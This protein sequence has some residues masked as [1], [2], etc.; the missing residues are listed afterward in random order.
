MS[1]SW[2]A[3]IRGYTSLILANG[4]PLPSRQ[5]IRLLGFG[6]SDDNT[7]SVL[8]K[9]APAQEIAGSGTWDQRS[10]RVNVGG[11]GART[12]TVPDPLDPVVGQE[13]LIAETAG[14]AGVVTI[15]PDG[16]NTINGSSSSIA[17]AAAGFT[18]IRLMWKSTGAWVR[19]S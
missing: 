6:A 5:A 19:V 16:S 1:T 11:S 8:N 15:D 2:L 4:T 13:L 17:L 9:Y 7:N 3:Y 10:D 12:I 14:N 18:F